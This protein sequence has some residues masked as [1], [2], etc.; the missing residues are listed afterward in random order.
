M[1]CYAAIFISQNVKKDTVKT[2]M[3]YNNFLKS[4]EE[5]EIF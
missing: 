3:N 5:N 1:L 2:N 4:D